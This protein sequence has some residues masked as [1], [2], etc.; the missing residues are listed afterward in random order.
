MTLI[1]THTHLFVAQ[2]DEDRNDTVKRAIASG[3]EVMLLPNIDIQSITKVKELAASFPN[4]CYAMMGIH[5]CD[6][7]EH[8]E[9]DLKI[10]AHELFSDYPYKA[11]GEIGID[12]YWDKTTRDIQTAAFIQQCRWA[13]ELNLPVSVH[14]REATAYTIELL[15]QEQIPNLRG[16][17]HCFTGTVEEAHDIISLDFILGIGGV[18]TYKN[19]DLRDTLKHIPLNRLVLE[20]DSP[21]LAPVPYR[22]KRNES[23]YTYEI[24]NAL[25]LVYEKT[26]LEIAEITSQT[27]KALFKI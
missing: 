24:A 6:I 11:V 16:V 21:Y 19:S 9:A 18:L 3:C 22:G 20:T 15:K 2:F 10:I 8:W 13:A 26:P 14:T 4:N 5:P 25:A 7:K 17:F 12:L 27:A 1:D 23:A